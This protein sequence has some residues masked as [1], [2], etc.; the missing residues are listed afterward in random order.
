[1]TKQSTTMNIH[2]NMSSPSNILQSHLIKSHMDT[3]VR[4][5]YARTADWD[6]LNAAIVGSCVA[7][8]DISSEATKGAIPRVG[9]KGRGGLK[10]IVCDCH[11][12]YTYLINN[13]ASV[14]LKI[15]SLPAPNGTQMRSKVHNFL[16][17]PGN[18]KLLYLSG[19]GNDKGDFVMKNNALLSAK[20]FL[21]W[22]SEAKFAGHITV[23]LDSCYS[24]MW[25][26]TFIMLMTGSDTC[27]KGLQEAAQQRGGKT[28]INLR[29]SS[30][31]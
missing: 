29:L 3:H 1:M 14:A 20:E 23:I 18:N 26:R 9:V 28:Y 6:Q 30:L 8:G 2:C 21:T 10:G 25:A 11:N 13:G 22:L 4:F 7:S 12:M 17:T 24:G 31:W 16:R 5:R 27:L 15:N 19:H